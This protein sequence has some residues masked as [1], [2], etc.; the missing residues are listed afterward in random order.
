MMTCGASSMP[1]CHLLGSIQS[2]PGSRAKA[3]L[4]ISTLC[5]LIHVLFSDLWR[6][7][8]TYLEVAGGSFGRV[9]HGHLLFRTHAGPQG[10]RC[11]CEIKEVQE[12][13]QAAAANVARAFWHGRGAPVLECTCL[14]STTAAERGCPGA[15]ALEDWHHCPLHHAA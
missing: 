7:S 4:R 2:R 6:T 10:P 13:P 11:R 8:E 3:R 5:T 15:A 1:Q 12:F 14:L 9:D